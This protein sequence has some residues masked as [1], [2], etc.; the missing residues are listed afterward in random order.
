MRYR[1]VAGELV[2]AH[3]AP[4]TP[5]KRSSLPCPHLIRDG[6]DDMW[7]PAT[8]KHYDSKAAFRAATKASGCIEVGDDPSISM[9]RTMD[10]GPQGIE[11][12]IKTA[13]EQLTAG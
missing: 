5:V 12:D 8:G 3:L 10:D 11:E 4:R 6:I 13:Y 9:A 2:P 7:H 1:L